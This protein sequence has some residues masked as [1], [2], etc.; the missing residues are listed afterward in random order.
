[1]PRTPPPVFA[2]APQPLR[3]VGPGAFLPDVPARDLTA[4]EVAALDVGG[5]ATVAALLASGLY[6]PV[7]APA[8]PAPQE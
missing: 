3:Y 8:A 7:P 6:A 1:M 4:D 2:P 5:V